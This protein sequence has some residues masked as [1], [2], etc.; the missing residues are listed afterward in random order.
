MKKVFATIVC[1]TILIT[2]ASIASPSFLVK[3]ADPH[4]V[5][6]IT[7]D[8][9]KQNQ[10][11]FAYPLLNE[12]GM[13]AT[14]YA[15]SDNVGVNP[16]DTID[17]Y[18]TYA[19]L[20]ELQASGNEIGSHSKTHSHLTSGLDNATLTSEVSG[21][22]AALQSHGLNV[23]NFAFP[24]GETNAT[25]DQFVQM[26][27]TSGRSYVQ[28]VNPMSYPWTYY[29][30]AGYAAE[31][32]N[33]A[34]VLD[35]IKLAIDYAYNNNKYAVLVFHNVYPGASNTE[36]AIS[37]TLFESVLQYI[38]NLG[39]STLTVHQVQTLGTTSYLNIFADHWNCNTCNW[40]TCLYNRSSCNNKCIIT[41]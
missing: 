12:Y 33:D 14:Y 15:I 37:T 23:Y 10:Y 22:K 13:V 6:S 9:A 31:T 16:Q 4:G 40:F 38:Q 36:Y 21:S 25:V 17:G 27:Y 5:I 35:H 20:Q 3:A 7:F 1:L 2:L 24:F 8:D 29:D 34:T 19:Q 39:I 11:Q 28:S 41:R 26:N 18:M 32:G 30:L